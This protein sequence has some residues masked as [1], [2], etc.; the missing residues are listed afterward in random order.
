MTLSLK[1]L[2]WSSFFDRQLD[3]DSGPDSGPDTG[4][5]SGPDSG[6]T[7]FR[8]AEVHRD[9]LTGL[10]P[11]GSRDLI[12]HGGQ[13]TGD[14]AVGDWVLAEPAGRIA[15]LLD[16]QTLLSRRAAGTDARVQLIAANVDTLYVVSSC[17]ADFN[18]ARLERY[19]ALAH[20]AGSFAVIVLTKA[21]LAAEPG[22]YERKARKIAGHTPVLAVDAFDPAH[23][24]RVA[25]WCGP[26]QTAALLGSSGVGKSTLRNGLVGDH[27]ETKA[28]R[29][30]DARGRHTTTSRALRRMGNGGWLIDTP[31][32][33]ALRLHGAES[34]IDGLFDDVTALAAECRFADC[35]H[36]AEPGC[37][38]QVAITAETLDPD[39][40]RRWQK[41]R[42]ENA[43]NSETL[44]EA[45]ARDKDFGRM[46]RTVM[47]DKKG[48]KGF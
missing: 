26:G 14:Y 42:R 24:A 20:E 2:G 48:Q 41:L 16:R 46:I 6:L 10:S 11:D 43:R 9:R 3:T 36:Q 37:A 5:D 13:S 8:I 1:D 7:G 47:R 40:L 44:A 39:R 34:G 4:P 30:D 38:V 25:E 33:R 27:A 28:I 15:R 12:L 22:D 18:Q 23:L 17:N 29:E 31:G 19:L 21:D 32:M 45:R 35:S